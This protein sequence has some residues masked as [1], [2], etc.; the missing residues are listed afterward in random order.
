MK[1]WLKNQKGLTLVELL[2]V[3]V[4]LG[5]IAAIAVPAIGNIIENSRKDAQ[6]ANAEALYDAA[7]LAQAG[8][9]ISG[10]VTFI[11]V[12][13][14]DDNYIVPPE[15]DNTDEYSLV[16]YIESSFPESDSFSDSYISAVVAVVDGEYTI[17][18]EGLEGTY[19]DATIQE[20]RED[21]R[22]V[23]EAP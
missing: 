13:E 15:N 16:N 7:R 12:E 17:T 23:V 1:K 22:D 10:D 4:I 21:G 14:N 8:D 6:I 20:I 2:A 19:I 5:I 3:I 18:L 11:A 9:N